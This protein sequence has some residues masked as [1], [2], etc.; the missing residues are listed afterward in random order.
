MAYRPE[1][2]VQKK[3][4]I[5]LDEAVYDGLSSLVGRGKISKFIEDLVRPHVMGGAMDEGY[6]AM[7][8]DPSREL[9]AQEW[10]EALAGDAADETR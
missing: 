9:A 7:A 1:V 2:A 5:S 3:I 6:R 4:T 10:I 8:A